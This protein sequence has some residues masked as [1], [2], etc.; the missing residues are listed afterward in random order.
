MDRYEKVMDLTISDKI[1]IWGPY[2]M[3]LLI[4]WFHKYFPDNKV[5]L[6]TPKIVNKYTN[7]YKNDNDKWNDFY[8]TDVELINTKIESD[9]IN[10]R[11]DIYNYFKQWCRN[12]ELKLPGFLDGF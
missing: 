12:N 3:T 5:K 6:I 8:Q 7:D 1:E 10:I 2:F 11:V 9:I 4:R